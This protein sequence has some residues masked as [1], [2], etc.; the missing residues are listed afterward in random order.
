M[1]CDVGEDLRWKGYMRL[2]MCVGI[3]GLVVDVDVE[4]GFIDAV[5][6]IGVDIF[7]L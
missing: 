7:A 5:V 3:L 1:G 6:E 4:I 2:R